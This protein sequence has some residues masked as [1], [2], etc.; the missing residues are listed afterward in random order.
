MFLFQNEQHFHVYIKCVQLLMNLCFDI[1]SRLALEA[2]SVLISILYLAVFCMQSSMM[3]KLYK[4]CQNILQGSRE[5]NIFLITPRK[6]VLGS[7]NCLE[8]F[9]WDPRTHVSG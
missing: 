3:T 2:S 6:N 7:K 9:Q 8:G 1:L 5:M 4:Q